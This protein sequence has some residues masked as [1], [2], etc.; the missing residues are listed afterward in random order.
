[1]TTEVQS[2]YQKPLPRPANPELTQPYWDGLREGKLLLPRCRQC[3]SFFWYPRD[4]CP[5]CLQANWEWTP[6]SGCGRI[7]TFTIVRQP[8]NP[9]FVADVPYAYAVI[10]L[11]EGVRVVSN[12]VGS[13]PE[14]LQVDMP[15][16]AV[17]D[18]VTPE[19][20]LLKFRVNDD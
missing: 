1:M 13:D 17:F 14:T 2:T 10:Q 19:W 9:A 12:V 15:V 6:A 3:G 8:A 11:D 7:Y 18:A 5:G 20:T 16:V 4:A